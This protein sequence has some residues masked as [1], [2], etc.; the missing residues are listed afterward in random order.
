V[1]RP[2]ILQGSKAMPA[3]ALRR[4]LPAPSAEISVAEA[5]AA[6][7]PA[8]AG[9]PWV[10]LTM[11]AS[12]DGAVV[13]DGASGGLGNPNDRDVLLT[14]RDLADVIV[15]GAGTARGEGYGPPRKP[16]QRIG[17]VTNSGKVDVST[18]LFTSG[19]GFVIAPESA[20]IDGSRCDVLRAGT[21]TVDLGRAIAA[22]PTIVG[23]A[24]H[25]QAEGGPTLN[26]S[27]LAADLVD[28][29]DLTVSPRMVGGAGPR[30]TS[31]APDADAR[32]VLAHLLVDDESFVFSRWLRRR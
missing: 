26:G 14:M 1:D 8:P 18:P 12:L 6:E 25:V 11:I 4:V 23:A 29:L 2:P 13:V 15:V 7:R 16:G 31:H 24:R 5:Y 9:R 32:F 27:L 10:G 21:D 28:E 22:L 20:A 17:V 3:P 19:A 30:L